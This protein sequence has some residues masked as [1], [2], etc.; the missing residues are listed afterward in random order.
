MN[1][2][3]FGAA[4]SKIE[5]KYFKATESLCK[6][7]AKSGHNLVFGA[8]GTGLMGAAAR[9]FKS[10]GGHITGVIPT[11][12]KDEDVELIYNECDELIFTE[13]MQERKLN[14]E[15][16]AD[17]FLIVPGGIGTYE[18]LFEILTLKQLRRHT[19]PIAIYNIDGY[20]KPLSKL[21]SYSTDTGFIPESIER[22]YICTDDTDK[23]CD[24]ILSSSNLTLSIDDMKNK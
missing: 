6:S 5:E 1:I 3:V 17:A 12:F 7:L 18:E 23:I 2:C 8:G 21:L 24:Y 19:K 16:L 15:N 10:G 20:Y 13:T 9:G 22:L 11:F 4:S 14:M